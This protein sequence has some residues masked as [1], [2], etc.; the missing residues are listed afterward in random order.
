MDK[1]TKRAANKINSIVEIIMVMMKCN[2]ETA[3]RIVT[4]SNTGKAILEG[5]YATLYQS[6]PCCVEDI[7]KELKKVNSKYVSYFTDD[8][9]NKA[10]DI[11]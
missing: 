5:D 3:Y 6:A 4:N 9:I 1:I 2:Y 10:I 11:M 7:G 8:K